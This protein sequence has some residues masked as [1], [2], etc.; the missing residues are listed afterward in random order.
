EGD[1]VEKEQPEGARRRPEVHV[2]GS[3]DGHGEHGED[4][5]PPAKSGTELPFAPCRETFGET[6]HVADRGLPLRDGLEDGETYCQQ[7]EQKGPSEQGA[8]GIKRETFGETAG[9]VRSNGVG[10]E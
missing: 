8:C 1:E 10:G 7:K 9:S 4:D 5:E 3:R 2:E 6:E